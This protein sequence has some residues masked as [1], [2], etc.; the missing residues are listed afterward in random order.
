M[1]LKKKKI[2]KV[3]RQR[4]QGRTIHFSQMMFPLLWNEMRLTMPHSQAWSEELLMKTYQWQI[5]TFMNPEYVPACWVIC[6]ILD[7]SLNIHCEREY[8]YLHFM[9]TNWDSCDALCTN[10][11]LIKECFAMSSIYY[12]YRLFK[13]YAKTRSA[14]SHVCFQS[15]K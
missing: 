13:M 5:F 12:Y 11:F 2:P 7:V 9:Y 3:K 4:G 6:M 1:Q 8:L 15:E 10:Y 14:K